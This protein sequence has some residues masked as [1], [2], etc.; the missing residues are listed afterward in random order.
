MLPSNYYLL[1]CPKSFTPPIEMSPVSSGVQ[2]YI[3][4]TDFIGGGGKTG[5]RHHRHWMNPVIQKEQF[6]SCRLASSR[7][8]TEPSLKWT[9]SGGISVGISFILAQKENLCSSASFWSFVCFFARSPTGDKRISL[10]CWWF[11]VHRDSFLF[12][13]SN[14]LA[15]QLS[16]RCSWPYCTVCMKLREVVVVH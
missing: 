6:L 12:T 3:T 13:V 5:G 1:L 14:L 4:V 11:W 16:A 9:E 7:A 10:F 8:Q 2:P 15:H